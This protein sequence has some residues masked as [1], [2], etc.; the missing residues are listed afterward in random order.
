M[1]F[2]VSALALALSIALFILLF[3][4][5]CCHLVVDYRQSGIFDLYLVLISIV[6]KEEEIVISFIMDVPNPDMFNHCV[7]H[8]CAIHL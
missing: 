1:G 6:P 5:F 2:A 8:V 7:G 3:V 4:L